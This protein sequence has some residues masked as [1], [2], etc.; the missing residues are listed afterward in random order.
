MS[1]K[2]VRVQNDVVLDKLL[3]TQTMSFWALVV[4]NDAVLISYLNKKK[5]SF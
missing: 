4:Q 3:L 2:V 1:F 5:K